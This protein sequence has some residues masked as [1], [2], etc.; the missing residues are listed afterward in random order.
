MFVLGHVGF[1]IGILLLIV[2]QKPEW[3]PKFDLRWLAIGAMLPDI[4]D[5]TIGLLILREYIDNGRIYA[6]TLAFSIC[7]TAIAAYI[8][9][10]P[11]ISV[12][13]GSWM[14]IAFDKMWEVPVTAF[15]PRYGWGFPKTDF[16]L[17]RWFEML[18]TDPYIQITEI[19]GASI[20]IF[21]FFKFQLYKREKWNNL[22]RTGDI[23]E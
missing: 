23:P 15:W 8:K 9:S 10:R 21:L 19:V 13:F 12:A 17:G 20:L 11:T 4:I 3:R 1:A 5:K 14:H 2:Y 18:L 6:H 22:W 16:Y 7:I